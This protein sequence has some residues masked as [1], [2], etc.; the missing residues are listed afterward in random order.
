MHHN[1]KVKVLYIQP[2][3]VRGGIETVLLTL[4]RSVDRSHFEPHVVFLEPGDLAHEVRAIGV[5]VSVFPTSHLRHAAETI[6]TVLR[7]AQY[8]RNYHIDVIHCNSSKAQIY[9]GLAAALTGIPDVYWLHNIPSDRLGVDPMADLAF[10]IPASI[11]LT[12]STET[13]HM[14]NRHPLVRRHPT[15][16]WYGLDFNHLTSSDQAAARPY[17]V[18][19]RKHILLIGRIQQ[20]KGQHVLIQAAHIL[21]RHRNDVCFDIVG[22]PTFAADQPYYDSLL[23]MAE[24]LGVA[25]VIN[26]VP[27]TNN[28]AAL[29]HSSEIVVHTSTTPEPFGLVVIEAMAAGRPVIAT[30]VGGPVDSTDNGNTGLLVPPGD[31]QALADAILRLLDDPAEASR[32]AERGRQ[33]VHALYSVDRMVADMQAVYEKV[34]H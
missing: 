31:P 14:T 11:R 26:F 16:L 7:L 20:W 15:I 18:S 12:N 1:H 29:Y 21:K 4:L 10:L 5:R 27:H 2:N 28:V 8:M 13:N 25:D 34:I 23:A 32:L 3:C 30:N 19:S 24:E 9:G 17:N 6:L 33:R 22:S